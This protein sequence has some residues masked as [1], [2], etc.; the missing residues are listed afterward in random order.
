[1]TLASLAAR[2]CPSRS[3]RASCRMADGNGAVC[4]PTGVRNFDDRLGTLDLNLTTA[5][6]VFSGAGQQKTLSLA[7][8]GDVGKHRMT[9]EITEG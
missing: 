2:K 6:L 8:S 3:D 7:K 4:A 5:R 9:F 1:M